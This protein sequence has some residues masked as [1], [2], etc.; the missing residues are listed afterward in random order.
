MVTG[1]SNPNSIHDADDYA[2]I[3]SM[4]LTR[5]INCW[6]SCKGSFLPYARTIVRRDILR[7]TKQIKSKISIYDIEEEKL[8]SS[9]IELG[10]LIDD[11]IGE[12]SNVEMGV[13]LKYSDSGIASTAKSFGMSKYSVRKIVNK[14]RGVLNGS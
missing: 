12:V 14:I 10:L 8:P 7:A 9:S 6:D 3:G 11:M 13:L 1:K 4:A 5:A 2:Q